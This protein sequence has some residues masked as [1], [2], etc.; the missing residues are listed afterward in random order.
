MDATC[1]HLARL[2]SELT[3]LLDAVDAATTLDAED[4]ALE[5]LGAWARRQLGPSWTPLYAGVRLVGVAG[6]WQ[7]RSLTL[8]RC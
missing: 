4:D 5:E 8:R 7:G 2:R 3:T 1:Q 6:E